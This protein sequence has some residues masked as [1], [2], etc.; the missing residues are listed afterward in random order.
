L[1]STHAPTELAESIAAAALD[2]KAV[3]LTL[4]DLRG[5]S[6]VTDFFVI[7]TA[8][9]DVHVRAIC[10]RIEEKLAEQGERPVAREGIANGRWALLDYGDVVV[11][12]FQAEARL[13]Y[14]LERLWS[15][16]PRFT[17]GSTSAIELGR[18]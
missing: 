7:C 4:L 9:S 3:D 8:R 11:H 17:S 6:S 2:R 12:V 1:T 14:D 10:D 13:F 5:V 15:H 16:A 18:P